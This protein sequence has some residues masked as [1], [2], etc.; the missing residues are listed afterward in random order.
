MFKRFSDLS[1]LTFKARKEDERLK[2]MIRLGDSD[3][4][5]K[6]KLK[7]ETEWEKEDNLHVFGHISDIEFC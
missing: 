7:N 6:T 1:F 3:L 4:I 5:M 2:T